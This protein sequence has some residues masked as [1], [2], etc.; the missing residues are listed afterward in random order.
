MVVFG[1]PQEG[2]EL[3]EEARQQQEAFDKSWDEA[4]KNYSL[5]PDGNVVMKDDASESPEETP[6]AAAPAPAAVEAKPQETPPGEAAPA[7]PEDKASGGSAQQV[8]DPPAKQD[9]EIGSAPAEGK[10]TDPNQQVA[11]S[12]QDSEV[13]KEIRA[14]REQVSKLQNERDSAQGRAVSFQQKQERAAVQPQGQPSPQATG[15]SL[16]EEIAQDLREISEVLPDHAEVL[17]KAFKR[18]TDRLEQRDHADAQ[19]ASATQ[20][21]SAQD[22]ALGQITAAVPGWE[23]QMWSN[24]EEPS[25]D[26]RNH[27]PEFASFIEKA[28]AHVKY[29][30]DNTEDPRVVIDIVKEYRKSTMNGATAPTNEPPVKAAPSNRRQIQLESAAAGVKSNVQPMSPKALSGGNE[31]SFDQAW[32]ETDKFF[33]NQEKE[34]AAS[35]NG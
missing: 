31:K 7:A 24:P 19:R 33:R 35:M 10:P 11:P 8:T 29:A 6:A 30:L 22:Q 12:Q 15:P 28:P 34:D 4:D 5:D 32:D 14:L 16:K 26:K 25:L 13:V 1:E 27:T 21:Q 9:G 2:E 17:G 20:A 23:K 3:T 18:I